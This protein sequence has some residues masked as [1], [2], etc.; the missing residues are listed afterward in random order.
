VALHK[1]EELDANKARILWAKTLSGSPPGLRACLMVEV[2]A[3]SAGWIDSGLDLRTGEEVSLFSAGTIWIAKDLGIGVKGDVAL[4]HQTGASGK[5]A[6][7][8]GIT[9]T[10]RAQKDGRLRLV[11]KPPGEWLDETGR[12]EPDCPHEGATGSLIVAVLVW[13]GSAREGLRTLKVL[14]ET[15]MAARELA[16]IE[17]T[18][19]L[20]PGWRHLWRVGETEIFRAAPLGEGKLQICC[21]TRGGAGILQYPLDLPLGR[22][23]RLAW[24]WRA[25]ELPS[26]VRED[27]FAAHDY[28]AIAV[29]FDNGR[30][31]TYM[32]SAALSEGKV[33][34]SPLPWWDKREAHQVVRSDRA[35]LGA[36]LE[37]QQPVLDDYERAV[38]G[39]PP[40]RIVGIWL[41]A[42][43][44][45]QRR[46]GLCCFAR[47][48][49]KSDSGE[50]FIG[51]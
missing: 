15:G 23:T 32:W 40:K 7:S 30:D 26:K 44:A 49:I 46:T 12:F 1:V 33:F 37:E 10:F 9:T 2:P 29:E 43:S 48:R 34:P 8:I 25:D 28:L 41:I 16:R 4:W 19:P 14:D 39:V 20:P 24:A 13:Q 17:A 47:I 45:F 50:L 51:P 27:S 35:K 18:P 11:A 38:G 42:K 5:V 22:S 3:Y 31:H 36:W 21:Q 6:K